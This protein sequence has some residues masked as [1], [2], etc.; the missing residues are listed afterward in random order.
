MRRVGNFFEALSSATRHWNVSGNITSRRRMRR[1]QQTFP[2]GPVWSMT[3]GW[4]RMLWHC[5]SVH[6]MCLVESNPLPLL[7][8]ASSGASGGTVMSQERAVW[9]ASHPPSLGSSLLLYLSRGTLFCLTRKANRKCFTASDQNGAFRDPH[10][11]F[12]S[13]TFRCRLSVVKQQGSPDQGTHHLS[14]WN[15]CVC[16]VS[17]TQ[18]RGLWL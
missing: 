9:H 8:H 6:F 10:N 3:G 2:V 16:Q 15:P 5:C 12:H 4:N 18:H 7:S 11:A 17:G 14:F 13:N 1:V